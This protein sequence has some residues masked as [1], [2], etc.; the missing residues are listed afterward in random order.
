MATSEAPSHRPCANQGAQRHAREFVV[1]GLVHEDERQD[2]R[3]AR[4]MDVRDR[5]LDRVTRRD[6]VVDDEDF[7]A[8]RR[9]VIGGEGAAFAMALFAGPINDELL[10]QL[11]ADQGREWDPVDRHAED[12]IRVHLPFLKLLERDVRHRRGHESDAVPVHPDGPPPDPHVLWRL[13]T[14]DASRQEPGDRLGGQ[15]QLVRDLLLGEAFLLVF[16]GPLRDRVHIFHAFSNSAA[17]DARCRI[18]RYRADA[19]TVSEPP[20]PPAYNPTFF[21]LPSSLT[22]GR[23]FLRCTSSAANPSAGSLSWKPVSF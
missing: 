6:D 14:L 10:P 20:S 13:A 1:G 22:Y 5:R 3:A 9:C 17:H 21:S 19:R 12:G 7:L 15:V 18:S 4:L 23:R 16:H 8:L 2:G 11:F